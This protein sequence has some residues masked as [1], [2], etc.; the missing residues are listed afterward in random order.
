[1]SESNVFY[2]SAPLQQT[3][4]TLQSVLEKSEVAGRGAVS[5]SLGGDFHPGKFEQLSDP[6]L[7]DR[8]RRKNFKKPNAV[9]ARSEPSLPGPS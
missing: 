2:V 8:C 4:R 7:T 6:V 3:R 9:S 5:R 1:M